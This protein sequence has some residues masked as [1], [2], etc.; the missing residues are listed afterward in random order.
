MNDITNKMDETIA[1]KHF[2]D[3]KIIS[4]VL[5]KHSYIVER[6]PETYSYF[7][8]NPEAFKEFY[9]DKF[10]ET[11]NRIDDLNEQR[12]YGVIISKIQHDIKTEERERDLDHFLDE[13]FPKMP[14]TL[15]LPGITGRERGP[16]FGKWYNVDE[17]EYSRK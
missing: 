15:K 14:K 2:S 10:K 1:K 11:A 17:T 6:I 9:Q 16:G 3:P 5:G 7:Q 12:K 13:V 4:K 8:K